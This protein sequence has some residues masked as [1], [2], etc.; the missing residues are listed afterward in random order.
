M[1]TM[2]NIKLSNAFLTLK[3]P[4]DVML[5]KPTMTL[6]EFENI[7][8]ITFLRIIEI[9]DIQTLKY[10]RDE[11]LTDSKKAKRLKFFIQTHL[12]MREIFA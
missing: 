11:V 9:N 1:S 7:N 8:T 6:I 10:L 3:K 2:F 12:D 5:I 4:T